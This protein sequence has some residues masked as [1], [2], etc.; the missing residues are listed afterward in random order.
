MIEES[1]D[2]IPLKR[3]LTGIIFAGKQYEIDVKNGTKSITIR[4]RWRDYRVGDTV[5]LGC[6]LLDWS[7]MGKI[8]Y[9][10]HDLLWKLPIEDLND[11]K[12]ADVD[13]AVSKLWQFYPEIN[14]R[15]PVTAIRWKLVK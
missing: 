11:D 12:F 2:P 8:T 3:P 13:D 15:S 5:L 14:H 6:H 9:V 7:A 10:R 1:T 4:T